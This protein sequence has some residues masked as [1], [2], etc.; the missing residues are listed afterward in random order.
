LSDFRTELYERYVSTFKESVTDDSDSRFVAFL[1]WC[2]YK[3]TPLFEGL[4]KDGRILE[5]GCGPGDMLEF[6]RRSGFTEI[7]GIDLSREQV[8]IATDRGLNARVADVFECLESSPEQ[9]RVIIAVDLVEHFTKDELMRLVPAIRNA[10][11]PGGTLI[12]QTPNGEGLFP[13]QVAYGDLT[14]LTI[15]T[16]DSLMQLFRLWG[17]GDFTFIEAGPVPRKLTGKLRVVAWRLI[18]WV[19]NLIRRIEAGKSQAIWTET[20]ICRCTKIADSNEKRPI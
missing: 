3:Y 18:R 17:F 9:Y 6:L 5:V 4:P 15:F 8:Q 2:A 12:L 16:P 7:E 10:L 11:A 13:N 20:M 14:H 19:A 1:D